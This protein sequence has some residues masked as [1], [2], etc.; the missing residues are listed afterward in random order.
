MRSIWPFIGGAIVAVLFMLATLPILM[1][2]A[3]V[4]ALS[5]GALHGVGYPF[6]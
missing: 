1:G 6:G 3:G 2:S 5:S 4:G